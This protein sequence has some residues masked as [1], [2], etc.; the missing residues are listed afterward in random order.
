MTRRAASGILVPILSVAVCGA[1]LLRG[2]ERIALPIDAPVLPVNQ[3]ALLMGTAS[4]SA[5]NC[6]GGVGVS[7]DAIF[8]KSS[9]I[10]LAEDKH[11]DAYAAL[12]SDRG[13]AMAHRLGLGPAEQADRC[14]ACHTTP[15]AVPAGA[16]RVRREETLAGVGCEA[17]HGAAEK[18]YVPHT[19][20]S[21]KQKTR[22]KKRQ[23]GLYLAGAEPGALNDALAERARVCAGCHVGA[24]AGGDGTPPRDVT[25]DLIAAGHPRLNFELGAFLANMP[26]HWREQ[27]TIG[28]EARVWEV[29]Q[30]ASAE[31]ALA[32]LAAR[33]ADETRPWPELAEY[34]CFACHHDLTGQPWPR[35][36]RREAAMGR[37]RWSGWYTAMLP[38]A[39]GAHGGDARLQSTIAQL[40]ELF[41]A[42]HPERKAVLQQA[43][44]AAT[45][46]HGWPE[47]LE[48]VTGSDA[49]A[50]RGRFLSVASEDQGLAE[51]GWD[52][53]TQYCLALAALDDA[54]RQTSPAAA[55]RFRQKHEA[56]QALASLLAFPVGY[57]SPKEPVPDTLLSKRLAQL[58][59]KLSD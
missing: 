5:R 37:L 44:A 23:F 26:R 40:R 59:K 12:T 21:W 7:D 55:A 51:R 56:V 24:A 27:K 3:G 48:N 9:T 57:D 54:Y 4:C 18:W 58:L 8:R 53:A 6:H 46:L 33:A 34:D 13:E 20:P 16:D 36:P 49:A 50:L 29:G 19:Q 2:A 22:A 30:A 1:L 45:A 42:S 39:L 10:W 14:L 32:L 17:C 38:R 25:H 15:F 43:R 41:G 31:A 47:R 35:E 11:A 52:E 28:F